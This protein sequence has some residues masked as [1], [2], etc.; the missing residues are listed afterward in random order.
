MQKEIWK[1]IPNYEGRYQCS[2]LGRV[3]SLDRIIHA[4]DG[5]NYPLKGR[6]KKNQLGSN[7]YLQTS[8]NKEGSC[9]SFKIHQ[10]VAI[11]FLNHKPNGYCMVVDHKDNNPLNNHIDNLQ[12][13]TNR[14]NSSKDKKG[15]TSKYVGVSWQVYKWIARIRI[16]G[17]KVHLGYYDKEYDAHLA[18]QAKLK[19]IGEI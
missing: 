15:G 4:K 1:D 14:Q 12:I 5:L 6:I 17:K 16:N 10:L 9:K 2:N 19:E 13:I 18:V 8:L 3:K 11:C 7:G